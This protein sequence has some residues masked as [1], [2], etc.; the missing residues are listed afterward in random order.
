MGESQF[1][2]IGD[3]KEK[4]LEFFRTNFEDVVELVGEKKLVEQYF[5]NPRLP[6]I[7]IKVLPQFVVSLFLSLIIIPFQMLKYSYKVQSISLQRPLCGY[8]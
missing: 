1:D 2:A 3:S 5:A 8:W 7:S 6:L 4:L